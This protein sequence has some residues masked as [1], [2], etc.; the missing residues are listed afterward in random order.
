LNEIFDEAAVQAALREDV[1][2]YFKTFLTEPIGLNLRNR[3]CHGLM[4]TLEFTRPLS[5]RVLHVLLVLAQV[6]SKSAQPEPHS[7]DPQAE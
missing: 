3:L 6:R 7:T 5:D 2:L 4:S 1:L